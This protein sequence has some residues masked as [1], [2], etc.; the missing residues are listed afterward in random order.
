MAGKTGSATMLA[1]YVTLGTFPQKV[2]FPVEFKFRFT[3][4]LRNT[5]VKG[6]LEFPLLE[7]F[8]TKFC[9]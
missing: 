3:E 5:V 4:N 2:L 1:V 7:G 8:L 6:E 9:S